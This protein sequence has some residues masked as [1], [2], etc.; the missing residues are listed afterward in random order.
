MREPEGAEHFHEQ[1]GAD[2]AH[3]QTEDQQRATGELEVG[4]NLGGNFR[5]GSPHLLELVLDPSDGPID[6]LLPAMGQQYAA[7]DEAGDQGE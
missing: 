6:V 2:D 5:G 3:Q 1:D 7:Q 4:G